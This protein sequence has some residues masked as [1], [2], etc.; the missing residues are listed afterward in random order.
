M[1]RV[2]KVRSPMSVGAWTL[3]AF[4]QASGAAGSKELETLELVTKPANRRRLVE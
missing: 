2:F 3:V 4:T 1:L